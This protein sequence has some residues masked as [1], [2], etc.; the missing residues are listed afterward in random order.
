MSEVSGQLRAVFRE[1]RRAY[2]SSRRFVVVVIVLFALCL[3]G[4]FASIPWGDYVVLF[5]EIARPVT[6]E[7]T[8][9]LVLLS[10]VLIAALLPPGLRRN[11]RLPSEW[12]WQLKYRPSRVWLGGEAFHTASLV[13]IGAVAFP[14]FAAAAWQSGGDAVG[15][16]TGMVLVV[17]TAYLSRELA[18]LAVALWE[19]RAFAP[20]LLVF[21]ALALWFVLGRHA[22]SPVFYLLESRVS[23]GPIVAIITVGLVFSSLRLGFLVLQYQRRL[24]GRP[25]FGR[26]HGHKAGGERRRGDGAGS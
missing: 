20:Y 18:L 11:N 26:G 1:E 19:Q 25:G 2:V 14:V 5:G 13:L 8:S 17:S 9:F 21:P 6:Y 4:F 7:V 12:I 22:A 24:A 3:A 15:A 23:A 16:L 10:V